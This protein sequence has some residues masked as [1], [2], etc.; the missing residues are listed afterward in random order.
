MTELQY[1]ADVDGLRAVAI[2]SVVAYHA[3][4]GSLSGGFV[5]VDVFFVISG[6]LITSLI[7][8]EV[9]EGRFSMLSFWA[10]RA[11]RLLPALFVLLA[12]TLTV[13][14]AILLPGD[15]AELADSS[16]A[17]SLFASNIHFWLNVSY[18]DNSAAL[19]PL[20]HTWSLAVEEQFYML[21]PAV[22][23]GA[24]YIRRPANVLL[25]LFAASLAYSAWAVTRYPGATFYLSPSR[26]WELLLGALLA[27]SPTQL[28]GGQ[29]TRN[30][31][32]VAGLGLIAWSVLA[33]DE[34]TV[35]PGMNALLPC[36]GA[37]MIIWART[38]II[39]RML[40]L[41][42]VVFIGLISYSLYLWHWPV[43]VFTRYEGYTLDTPVQ[44]AAVIL[45]SV[46]LACLSWR[47]VELPA[48]RWLAAIGNVRV[49]RLSGGLVMTACVAAVAIGQTS[50]SAARETVAPEEVG[51]DEARAAYGEGVCFFSSDAPLSAIDP[52]RCLQPASD[53]ADYLLMGDSFA[54]HLS[55]GLRAVLPEQSLRQLNFG[56][57]PPLRSS[58]KRADPG[59]R[60]VTQAVFDAV[61][62][63]RYDVVVVAS[64]WKEHE[65]PELGKMLGWLKQQ[66]GQV[67]LVGPIVEYRR[68]LPDIIEGSSDPE[69]AVVKYRSIP[70]SLD[71]RMRRLADDLGIRYVSLVDAMCEGDR[72]RLYDMTGDPIQ[73][74]NGHLTAPGSVE[75]M[76][77]I[78]KE[79]AIPIL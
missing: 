8:A 2:S 5:G 36:L 54:A 4:V 27:I 18:F 13:G 65:L 62:Q 55:P 3:G 67:V 46:A 44:S 34:A 49:L 30:I 37:A 79:G 14:S 66:S 64:R 45:V 1:R 28:Y 21:F 29:G 17:A 75:I 52:A 38:G 24:L 74:D 57:C 15:Y 32:S 25:I 77:D 48:K 53:G 60:K 43:I 42:P 78:V 11:R 35:F 20:L 50:Q 23:L 40:S 59:C 7:V 12:V 9:R 51:R 41:R 73:W 31:A 22:M 56:G 6:F 33:F 61:E 26:F 58:L 71:R 10:R 16:V 72:C 70:D 76:G 69:R 63:T 39:N 47:Y 68:Y 19:N